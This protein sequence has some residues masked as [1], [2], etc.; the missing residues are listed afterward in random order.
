MTEAEA[1]GQPDGSEPCSKQSRRKS[2]KKVA[3]HY[4][5]A[6]A[7]DLGKAWDLVKKYPEGSLFDRRFRELVGKDFYRNQDEITKR[8]EII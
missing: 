8:H 2:P 6:Y 5:S 1:R 7:H 4:S 3:G